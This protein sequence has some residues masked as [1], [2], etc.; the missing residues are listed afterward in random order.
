[1]ILQMTAFV[2]YFLITLLLPLYNSLQISPT[3]VSSSF[4]KADSAKIIDGYAVGHTI[5]TGSTPTATMPFPGTAFTLIPNL[6]YGITQ[7]VGSDSLYSEMYEIT[8][9]ALTTSSFSVL[10]QISGTTYLWIL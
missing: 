9:T 8:R 2:A 1:M 7:Y 4:V 3:W 6:G 5:G 10:V